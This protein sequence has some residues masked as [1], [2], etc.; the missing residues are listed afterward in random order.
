MTIKF[1][2]QIDIRQFLFGSMVASMHYRPQSVGALRDRLPAMSP[3]GAHEDF[4]AQLQAHL[5]HSTLNDLLRARTKLGNDIYAATWFVLGFH[6]WLAIA[7]LEGLDGP[8]KL[9]DMDHVGVLRDALFELGIETDHEAIR[10][11][12]RDT[13]VPS[14]GEILK[15]IDNRLCYF[16]NRVEYLSSAA[17][18]CGQRTGLHVPAASAFISYAHE[19]AD[20]V[21]GMANFLEKHAVNIW[22][23]SDDLRSAARLDG[24]LRAGIERQEVFV[25]VLSE[26]SLR[27]RWV[28]L[29]LATALKL[30]KKILP[31]SL[32]PSDTLDALR[33][34]E[35]GVALYEGVM[36]FPVV[37]CEK[38]DGWMAAYRRVLQNLQKTEL[39]LTRWR[40]DE[41]A[42][43]AAFLGTMQAS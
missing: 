35:G 26:A 9:P 43:L 29:E 28:V 33:S 32:V 4:V 10:E 8:S 22:L 13:P 36:A 3:G 30:G 41:G 12:L 31:I 14:G 20:L 11:A 38:N 21:N 24:R 17:I 2:I 39:D 16:S 27:S 18:R 37:A 19:D 42:A 40:Q 23:D 1:P 15:K 34:H 6:G 7:K 5:Y 25:V